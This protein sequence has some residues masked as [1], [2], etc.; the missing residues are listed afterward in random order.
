[1]QRPVRGRSGGRDR[2]VATRGVWGAAWMDPTFLW[3]P[4]APSSAL[5]S[6]P[7]CLRSL[8]LQPR[9]PS[10]ALWVTRGSSR[11]SPHPAPLARALSWGEG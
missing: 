4:N 1:M 7:H 8:G 10:L 5:P 6:L 2:W 11:P 9:L 3:L